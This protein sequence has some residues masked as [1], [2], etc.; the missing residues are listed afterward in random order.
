MRIAHFLQGRCNSDSA[1]G[2]EKTIYFLSRAQAALGH[3]VAVFSLTAKD[4][5]P[6]PGVDV[7][8]YS[9]GWHRF[10]IPDELIAD[11]QKWEPALVHLHSAY[12]PPNTSLARHLRRLQIPYVVTPNGVLASALL[13]RRPYIKFPYK[14]LFELPC[15]NRAAFVHAVGDEE[16]IRKYGVRVP[17]VVAPNGFD[18]ANVPSDLPTDRIEREWPDARG[19]K[20]VIFVGRLDIEQK[21]LDMLLQGF[22]EAARKQPLG[23][24]LVGPD[25]KGG[26]QRLEA[27][28]KQLGIE[29][30]VWFRGP[31]FGREKFELL[32]SADV[33][34]YPSRWEGLPF[35]VVEAL[36]TQ[37]PCIVTRAADPLRIVARSGAG[38]VID[39]E[40]TMIANAIT[41]LTRLSKR[42]LLQL[43]SKAL[44]VLKRELD[45]T[46]IAQTLHAG[47]GEHCA[48]TAE[49][50]I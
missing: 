42:E 17:I 4:A 15:L 2:V 14:H 44:A 48:R 1:N 20:I 46:A 26:R 45:W 33:F 40:V 28:A 19:R 41:T 11:L 34:I 6:I 36:A 16:E 9:P 35:S 18:L 38:T 31:A 47:Y 30:E 12:V 7:R 21:G 50:G 27:S 22:R 3:D 37:R 25:W 39:L 13:R 23:L 29:R 32:A 43:G 8:K 24:V 5:L 10:A 49:S